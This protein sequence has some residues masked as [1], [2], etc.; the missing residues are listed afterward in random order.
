VLSKKQWSILFNEALKKDFRFNRRERRNLCRHALLDYRG[1]L[2]P[3]EAVNDLTDFIYR[4]IGFDASLP[5]TDAEHIRLA[6]WCSLPHPLR[7]PT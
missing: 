2:S 1:K 5:I 3:Q 6:T 7:S 4:T